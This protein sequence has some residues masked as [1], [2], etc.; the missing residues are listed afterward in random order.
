MNN[1]NI[2]QIEMVSIE[3]LVSPDHVYRQYQRLLNFD[4]LLKGLQQELDHKL[5]AQGYGIVCLFKCL[6]LQVMEDL[7][8]REL[9][10]Y[11]TDKQIVEIVATISIFGFLNRWNDSMATKLEEKPL[12]FAREH[13]SKNWEP[14]KHVHA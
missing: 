12:S 5:G 3:D 2:L 10:K 8:D 9:E 1:N 14:G 11:F 4:S 6:L 13:L 7:S